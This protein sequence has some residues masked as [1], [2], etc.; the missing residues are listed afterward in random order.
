HDKLP[1]RV[2]LCTARTHEPACLRPAF[3]RPPC[4]PSTGTVYSCFF[5]ARVT[6]TLAVAGASP[7]NSPDSKSFSVILCVLV[8]AVSP[9]LRSSSERLP[10]VEA[11]QTFCASIVLTSSVTDFATDA[12]L[13]RSSAL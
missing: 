8:S 5:D 13:L 11:S 9:A 7:P 2:S 12:L 1:H 3:A 6:T 10:T 4:S